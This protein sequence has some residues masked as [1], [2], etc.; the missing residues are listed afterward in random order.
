MGGNG[1][2]GGRS[3]ARR[4]RQWGRWG[5]RKRDAETRFRCPLFWPTKQCSIP[6]AL[7]VLQSIQPPH[8]PHLFQNSGRLLKSVAFPDFPEGVTRVT[9]HAPY[10]H[11]GQQNTRSSHQATGLLYYSDLLCSIRALA[12]GKPSVSQ[13]VLSLV[14]SG[15]HLSIQMS[16]VLYSILGSLRTSDVK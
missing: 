11:F 8:P 13:S 5:R 9:S 15:K 16:G 6:C 12:Q 10:F 1:D 2:R 3:R 14:R 7:I 4:Q